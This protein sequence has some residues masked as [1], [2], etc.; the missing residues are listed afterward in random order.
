MALTADERHLVYEVLGVPDAVSGLS[1]YADDP[2]TGTFELSILT[3]K[4]QIDAVLDGIDAGDA[5][6]VTRLQE[7]LAAWKPVSISAT[8][9]H[10][11]EGNQGVD[12]DPKKIRRLIRKAVQAIVPVR[13]GGIDDADSSLPLA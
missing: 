11:L 3:A 8:R 1:V 5:A 13:V 2:G 7:L 12:R 4:T 10:P 9:L 6:L